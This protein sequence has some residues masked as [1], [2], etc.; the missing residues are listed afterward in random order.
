MKTTIM[1]AFSKRCQNS[2]ARSARPKV[3]A[4]LSATI[5]L[6]LLQKLK[7]PK[8]TEA[9]FIKISPLI[10]L[11]LREVKAGKTTMRKT[12]TIGLS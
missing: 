2:V 1:Q 6:N 11:T 10:D 5:C 12:R 8:A 3:K 9:K 7:L 4:L